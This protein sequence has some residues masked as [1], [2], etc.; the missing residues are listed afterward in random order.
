MLPAAKK[1]NKELK[2]FFDEESEKGEV[3][4]PK[5]KDSVMDKMAMITEEIEKEKAEQDK[6]LEKHIRELKRRNRDYSRSRSRDRDRGGRRDLKDEIME[7]RR[8]RRSRSRKRRSSSRSRRRGG[9]SG[10]RS[11]GQRSRSRGRRSRS[12]GRRS[13]SRGS[14]R[15]RK[16]SGN[17]S[18]SRGRGDIQ[19]TEE[20]FPLAKDEPPPPDP[21]TK[22]G[23]LELYRLELEK[24]AKKFLAREKKYRGRS[25]GDVALDKTRAFRIVTHT[26]S[27]Q[28]E[29]EEEE[30]E[31][32]IERTP[33]PDD[34]LDPVTRSKNRV[35]EVVAKINNIPPPENYKPE[36]EVIRP[37][38]ELKEKPVL[39]G[40]YFARVVPEEELRR[41]ESR[42]R[43]T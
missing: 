11:R 23:R 24:K 10:S 28:P 36:E 34:G 8:R 13:K 21:T 17:R 26:P 31:E 14:R 3:A 30:F 42:S 38:T 27:P 25:P 32:E 5:P 19:D 20:E 22:E 39:V 7:E 37:E 2:K 43:S 33:E 12:R 41:Y 1:K 16:R 29:D 9:R 4:K 6:F 40:G 18:L 15:E 35:A